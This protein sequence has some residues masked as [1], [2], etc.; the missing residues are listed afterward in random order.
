MAAVLNFILEYLWLAMLLLTAANAWHWKFAGERLKGAGT[1]DSYAYYAVLFFFWAGIPW[2]I[3]GA[4]ILMGDA[5]DLIDFFKPAEGLP[6]VTAFYV[7]R[8]AFDVALGYWLYFR[9][10][11]TKIAE[12]PG[13]FRPADVF[14]KPPLTEAFY[15]AWMALFVTVTAVLLLLDPVPGNWAELG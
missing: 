4:G 1:H 8:F 6:S 5:R 15:W 10:G 13:I 9:D 7:S 2:M 3:M 14:N 12:H 11:F